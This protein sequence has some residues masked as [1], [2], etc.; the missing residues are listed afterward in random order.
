MLSENI[1]KLRKER[2]LSQ[3]ELAIQVHV[4]RQTLSKWEN[5]LSVPDADQLVLLADA[6]GV[7]V[8]TLLG[9]ELDDPCDGEAIAAE[10]ERANKQIARHAEEL[11]EV[12]KLAHMSKLSPEERKES[13]QNTVNKGRCC[14]CVNKCLRTACAT[15]VFIY[16]LCVGIMAVNKR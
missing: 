16:R 12:A 8:G 15:I 5:N 7:S 14:L 13:W 10:L 3:E 11:H 4:V 1:K 2:G 6:L 9:T